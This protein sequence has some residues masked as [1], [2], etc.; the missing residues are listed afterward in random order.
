MKNLI[1]NRSSFDG[2]RTYGFGTIHLPEDTQTRASWPLG[3]LSGVS[4]VDRKSL[5]LGGG[6]GAAEAAVQF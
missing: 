2:I 6:E 1:G 4:W 3:E 5:E